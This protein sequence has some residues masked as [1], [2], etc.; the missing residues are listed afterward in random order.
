MRYNTHKFTLI[1]SPAY[2]IKL[3]LSENCVIILIEYCMYL[4][5]ETGVYRHYR[6]IWWAL[7][8]PFRVHLSL[9]VKSSAAVVVVQCAL[10][11]V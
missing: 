11:N 5:L 2:G 4:L 3:E 9:A 10:Y 8:S 6:P 7:C 1:S